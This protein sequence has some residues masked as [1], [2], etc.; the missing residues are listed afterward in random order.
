MVCVVGG[1]D[2]P[3]NLKAA[4]RLTHTLKGSANLIGVRGVANLAHH[5]E[6]ILEYLAKHKI[7][8][9]PALAGTLQKAADCLEAMIEALQGVDTAPMDAMRILQ[10]VLDWAK[11]AVDAEENRSLQN[12]DRHRLNWLP[13]LSMNSASE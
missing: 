11:S 6:D 10:E 2:V 9:P 1:E 7:T 3:E 5:L 12:S 4:Q 8:P 13:Q